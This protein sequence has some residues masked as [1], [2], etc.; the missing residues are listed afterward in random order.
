M[1]K[2]LKIAEAVDLFHSEIC[3]SSEVM[4]SIF[5]LQSGTVNFFIFHGWVQIAF[6]SHHGK[7]EEFEKVLWSNW[8]HIL[9]SVV[10]YVQHEHRK[11][12]TNKCMQW[13]NSFLRNAVTA[14][15][16]KF[17]ITEKTT[18][19]QNTRRVIQLS[20]THFFLPQLKLLSLRM[21]TKPSNMM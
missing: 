19:K 9:S 1:R 11:D 16:E 21:Y 10:D 15:N 2:L 14:D 20:E 5:F 18:T 3:V 7:K 4:K 6:H 12:W 17:I 13:W 8:S